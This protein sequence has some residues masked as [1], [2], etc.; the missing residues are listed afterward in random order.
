MVLK[1]L[2]IV[3]LCS[4]ALC[5]G[6]RAQTVQQSSATKTKVD[7]H[8]S[9]AHVYA[10]ATSGSSFIYVKLPGS[11]S[12]HRLTTRTNGWET[13]PTV[14]PSGKL[15]AYAVSASPEAKSEVWV[16]H[17]DGSHAHRVSASDEDALMP[18]FAGDDRTVLYVKSRFNGHYS[19]IARPRRHEFDVMKVIVDA[20]GPIAGANPVQLTHQHFFDLRSLSVSPDGK[21][22]LV[23]T[24][25]YPIGDLIEGF[26]VADPL[27]IKFIYQPHVPSEPSTGAAF[28]EAAYINNGMDIVFTAATEPPTGGNFDYSIY[29]MSAITGGEITILYR[30]SGMIDNLKVGRDGTIFVSADGKRYVLDQQMHIL[31]QI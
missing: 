13:A 8:S 12:A 14:S 27:Q 30:H 28:G 20:D 4:L 31:K 2:R 1:A 6:C 16:S 10:V 17:I 15:I 9:F 5:S 7:N 3:L 22:F 25:G 11:A 24:S 19:P 18:A 26:D 23:S 29:K 21:N